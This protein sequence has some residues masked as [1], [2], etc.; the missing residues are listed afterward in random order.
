MAEP[1]ASS[2]SSSSTKAPQDADDKS[3]RRGKQGFVGRWL[4][5]GKGTEEWSTSTAGGVGQSE[6]GAVSETQ[7]ATKEAKDEPKIATR[8]F[9]FLPVPRYLRHDPAKP[10]E[11]SLAYCWLF[12]VGAMIT[13]CALFLLFPFASCLFLSLTPSSHLRHRLYCTW[14]CTGTSSYLY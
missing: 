9:G 3:D 10:F 6:T 2:T 12:G 5:R 14:T 13:V 7:P 1:T 4:G 11:L 8:E